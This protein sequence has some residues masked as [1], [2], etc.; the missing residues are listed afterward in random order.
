MGFSCQSALKRGV[1]F[2]RA[3]IARKSITLSQVSEV[4]IADYISSTQPIGWPEGQLWD[5]T[6]RT[7][8]LRLINIANPAAGVD[9]TVTIPINTR[10]N[11][12]HVF[13]TLTTSAAAANRNPRLQ[14]TAGGAAVFR[15]IQSLADQLASLANMQFI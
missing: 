2:V 14:V 1:T 12:R 11:L 9:W 10:W 3:G 8:N 5:C 15:S 7:G 13:A 6:D 4:L